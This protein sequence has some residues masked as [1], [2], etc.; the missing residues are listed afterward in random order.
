MTC[1]LCHFPP[2]DG[3]V[4]GSVRHDDRDCAC[5]QFFHYLKSAE[6]NR[7][8]PIPARYAEAALSF[9]P[10]E[11]GRV[12]SRELVH[13]HGVMR[14]RFI[15]HLD[16]GLMAMIQGT[17]GTGKSHLAAACVNA[18]RGMGHFAVFAPATEIESRAYATI[19][20]DDETMTQLTSDL[21][22]CTLLAVDD[23]G[24]NRGTEFVTTTLYKV[25]EDRYNEKRPTIITTNDT[26]AELARTFGP[27]KSAALID[28]MG[29]DGVVILLNGK[30]MRSGGKG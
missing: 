5:P 19:D 27:M 6:S 3:C 12:Y 8:W 20:T 24:K 10:P 23:I 26:M 13:A 4:A 21:S 15:S 7:R 29:E 30:S 2:L 14:D 22:E 16:A 17:V 28:R 1:P 11:S 25:I 18:V 9:F